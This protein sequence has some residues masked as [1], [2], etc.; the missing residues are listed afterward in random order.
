MPALPES[1]R[2]VL[3]EGWVARVPGDDDIGALTG[4]LT[5]TRRPGST[6][7]VD[8]ATLTDVVVGR[9]SWTRR[10][11]GVTDPSSTLVG[12]GVVHDRAA[13]RIEVTVLV[14]PDS[15]AQD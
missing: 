12:W 8:V 4:L 13:G 5:K 14:D 15:S 6:A 2:L 9:E 11:L 10:Q 7:P 3:P 1:E